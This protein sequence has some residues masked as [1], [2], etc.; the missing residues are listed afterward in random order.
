MKSSTL[1]ETN[2]SEQKFLLMTV[3]RDLMKAT[4][5]FILCIL[6]ILKSGINKIKISKKLVVNFRKKN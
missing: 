6:F 4:I 3:K 2:D 1:F 5:L